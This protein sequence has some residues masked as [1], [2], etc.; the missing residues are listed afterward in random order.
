MKK[1]SLPGRK[2]KEILDRQAKY[3]SPSITAPTSLV[4]ERAEDCVVTD[5]DGNTFIDFS[6]GVLV[7]NTGHCHPRVVEAV[8]EAAGSLINCYDAA[9]PLR[10]DLVEKLSS[11]MPEDLKR[12]LLLSTGSEAVEA[13]IKVARSYSGR[14]E[15]ISFQGAF[16][17][18]TYMAMSVAG[19]A[20]VKRGFGPLVPGVLH[21][22]FPYYYRRLPGETEEDV[23]ARCLAAVERL[24]ET[25]SAGSIAALIT[26]PYQ[27]AAGSL[28][29]SKSFIQSL[30]RLCDDNDILFIFDEVQSSFGRT[31]SLFAFEHYDI[32]PDIITLAKGIA[33]GVPTSAVIGRSPIMETLKPG[34]LSS[35]FGGNPISCAAAL[36]SIEVI[37]D[38]DLSLNSAKIGDL[39]LSR[40]EQMKEEF[41]LIGDVRGS[42]LAIAV[43]L[44]RDRKT[45]EP[46][47]EEAREL[48]DRLIERGL[49][50]IPPIGLFGNVIRISPP[51]TIPEELATEGLDILEAVLRETQSSTNE[52]AR[53]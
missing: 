49:A 18:R 8:Q 25:E 27:G 12:V 15:I 23:D 10:A 30:R 53:A 32:V 33:S 24:I 50:L 13:A 29:P 47:P 28:V 1:Y 44:V 14:F 48:V 40:L 5:I 6:S 34:S 41:E 22:P 52:N 36:A 51:L 21:A 3:L 20:G 45:K 2:A 26:E 4:W 38:E 9:H 7:T 43:E 17:G 31:G 39:M 35:T 46:A 37:L 42:G 19:L 11:L 16:H